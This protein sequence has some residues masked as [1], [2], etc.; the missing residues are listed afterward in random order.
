MDELKEQLVQVKRELE[1][2]EVGL[3]GRPLTP[4]DVTEL[5]KL[6]NKKWSIEHK[7]HE[8]ILKGVK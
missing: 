5:Q 2:F 3:Q 7:L 8:M 1:M 4:Y 6:V